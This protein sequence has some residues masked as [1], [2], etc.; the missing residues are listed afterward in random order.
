MSLLQEQYVLRTAL[1][2]SECATRIKRVSAASIA[3]ARIDK[4]PPLHGWAD[5]QSFSLA[6]QMDYL[7]TALSGRLVPDGSGTRIYAAARPR[8]WHK[9]ILALSAILTFGFVGPYFWTESQS[10]PHTV[11][12]L[13][14]QHL[15]AIALV[16]ML[17]SINI[18]L[19]AVFLRKQAAELAGHLK[20]M[21][22]AN[23]E[24]SI[25]LLA[26]QSNFSADTLPRPAT[27]IG[28]GTLALVALHFLPFMFDPENAEHISAQLYDLAVQLKSEGNLKEADLVAIPAAAFG[29]VGHMNFSTQAENQLIRP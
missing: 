20:K 28:A 6:L 5:G 14:F 1:G 24:T 22:E 2:Q 10:L 17:V 27:I 29:D 19:R 21:L 3:S 16:S 13:L 12:G 25:I 4:S 9:I 15:N 7:G 18:F 26:A 23:E 8:F 11:T